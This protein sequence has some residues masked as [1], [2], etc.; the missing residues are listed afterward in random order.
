[1]Y[2]YCSDCSALNRRNGCL[3]YRRGAEYAEFIDIEENISAL[4]MIPIA[5]CVLCA[6]AVIQS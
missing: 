6:S 4:P 2:C 5:L 1:M 3:F